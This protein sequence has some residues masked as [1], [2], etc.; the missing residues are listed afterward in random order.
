MPS[1]VP[2]LTAAAVLYILFYVFLQDKAVEVYLQRQPYANEVK[3][4]VMPCTVPILTAAIV[5]I[6]KTVPIPTA[7]GNGPILTA[8]SL[9]QSS[10]GF[11][12]KERVMPCTIPILTEAGN[13]PN[14]MAQACTN[15]YGGN[16]KR[17]CTAA[18]F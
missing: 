16:F 18:I 5:P 17:I 4:Q 8:A 1:T 9:Y 13:G 12:V 7:V 2:I 14:L 3:E 10:R 6:L 15:P 11:V